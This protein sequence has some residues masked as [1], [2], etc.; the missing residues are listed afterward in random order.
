MTLGEK[1][2]SQRRSKGLSQEL[3]AEHCGISLRTVQRIE[4]DKSLPRPYTLKVIAE[5]LGVPVAQLESTANPMVSKE[6]LSRLN[7]INSSAL[8]GILIPLLN[9]IVPFILWRRNRGNL[10]VNEKGKKIVSF[11]IL[12]FLCTL[13]VLLATHFFHYQLTGQFM[14]GRIP[15]VAVAYIVLL[16]TNMFFIVR[17]SLRLK[18][19]NTEIYRFVPNLF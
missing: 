6:W 8:L 13:S 16:F 15:A 12:W 4:R 19:K 1:I 2:S 3:L 9:I 14:T 7:L 10:L 11:Q 17:N 18:D 5:A